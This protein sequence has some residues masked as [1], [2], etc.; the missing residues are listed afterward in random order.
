MLGSLN[1]SSE[2]SIL[3]K[4]NYSSNFYSTAGSEGLRWTGPEPTSLLYLNLHKDRDFRVKIRIKRAVDPAM[5]E[6]FK[7]FV[8]GEQI[9]L[10][11]KKNEG[12]HI[13]TGTIPAE[14]L[15]IANHLVEFSLQTSH[16]ASPNEKDARLLGLL[17]HSLQ[18]NPIAS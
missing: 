11:R 6:N 17:F 10:E 2:D 18:L 4:P 5:I 1:L 3:D 12:L 13:F 7:L 8:N 16:T 14:V 9:A 15:Q